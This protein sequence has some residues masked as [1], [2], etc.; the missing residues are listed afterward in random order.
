MARK[1]RAMKDSSGKEAQRKKGVP[2][3]SWGRKQSPEAQLKALFAA[4]SDVIFV[5]DAKGRYL[6]VAPTS[7]NLLSKPAPHLIGQTLHEVFPATQA[8]S[9]LRCIQRTLKS[10]KTVNTEYCL[11]IHGREVWFSAAISPMTRDSVVWVARDI[12]ERKEAER[13]VLRAEE[14]YRSLFSNAVIGMYQSTPEGK[15]LTANPALV[16]MLGFDSLEELLAT[17]IEGSLYVDAKVRKKNLEI[18]HQTGGFV[19]EYEL[20][21][22]DGQRIVVE[23]HARAVKDPAG[24]LLY[25]EGTLID[26]TERRRAEE[27]LKRSEEKYRNL[28]ENSMVGMFRSALADGTILEANNTFL[29][30]FGVES[31]KGAHAEDSYVDPAHREHMKEQ[32]LKNGYVENFE[33]QL[34]RNDGSV[35][36]VS[37][38]GRYHPEDDSLGGVLIDITERKRSEER[39]ERINQCFLS[40]GTDPLENI[41]QL[42]SLCGE[43]LGASYAVYNRL[44]Q[45][46]LCSWGQWKT[47][48]DFKVTDRPEGHLC[49]EVIQKGGNELLLVRQLDQTSYADTDPNVR[50][51]GLRTYMGRCIKFGE[52]SVGSLCVVYQED[53]LPSEDDKR[54]MSVIASAIGVEEM[55]KQAREELRETNQRLQAFI[56]ASPLAIMCLDPEGG[57]TMWSRAAERLFGWNEAEVL[58]KPL[59]IVPKDKQ[60]EFRRLRERVMQEEA[61]T[62]IELR[63]KK[64]DGTWI[65]VSLSAAPLRDSQGQANGMIGLMAD[66]TERKRAEQERQVIYDIMQGVNHT[67]NLDELLRL[68]HRSL[69]RVIYAENCFI[70]L[71]NKQEEV[72]EFPFFVDQF[73]VAPPPLKAGKSCTAFV[74]RMG[75]PILITEEIFR[76]LERQGEVENVGT[77]SP[78]WLGVPLKTPSETIGVLVVQHYEDANAY[79]QRDGEFLASVGNQVALAIDRKRT[80]DKLRQSEERYRHLVDMSPEGIIIHSE[81]KFAFLNPAATQLL[82]AT[83]QDQLIGKPILDFVHSDHREGVKERLYRLLEEGKSVPLK[84]EKLIRLD[85]STVD[86]EVAAI[87]F[88]FD[89]RPAVQVIVRDITARREAENKI[90]RLNRLYS[91]LSKINKAIVRIREPERLYEE[92]CRIVVSEGLFRMAWVGLID[93]E[94]LWVKPVAHWGYEE[95]YLKTLRVS[96]ANIAEGRGPVGTAIRENT[97]SVFNDFQNDVRIL[98]WREEATRRG[99]ASCTALPLRIGARVIGIIALYSGELGFFD[100]DVIRLLDALADDISFALELADQ[101]RQ[102]RQA[103]EA[104]KQS[105]AQ[106]LQ[107]QKMEAVG[108]LA[109]GVAHDFNNFLTAITGYSDLMLMRLPTGDPLRHHAEEIHKAADRAASLTQQLLAFSRKQILQPKVVDLNMVVADVEKM[110]RRLIGEDIELIT[111]L[112]PNL[113]KIKADPGQ[114]V[115]VLMN[116]AVNARDAMAQ[117]GKLIVETASVD[118]DQPHGEMPAGLHVMLSVRDTGCGMDAETKSHI[119]EPFFTTKEKGKGTG[120]GLSTVYGIVKLSGGTIS[121]DSELG[122]GSTFKVYLPRLEEALESGHRG[123]G[124]AS[125][126]R[127]AETVLLVEDEE[128]VRDLVRNILQVHGYTV[129]EAQNGRGAIE[130]CEQHPEHIDLILTD[131][132]MPQM[133]GRELVERLSPMKPDAKILYMS[134]YTDDAILHHGTLESDIPFLQK[135][136]TPDALVLKVREVLDALR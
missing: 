122:Q 26:I 66:I 68:I 37:Y 88:T 72:F 99:Y 29:R 57:V 55:R 15:V 14:K 31:Y 67:A 30:I 21:R 53:Y 92:A 18:F 6:K 77:P 85:G 89:S 61:L 131:V 7:P 41:Q 81:G 59:P 75:R 119:F 9:F 25:C 130:L 5:L 73:D 11:P 56:Q 127:G 82:G 43:M 86:V 39:L 1:S 134:G 65:D 83:T 34:K 91:V 133:S 38:S 20:K 113:G 93:P 35:F 12:S 79:N 121:I 47:P 96:A 36:W 49:H 90:S 17:D 116:L 78:A 2:S 23:E 28:F 124:T 129:L 135:P 108:R 95:G 101:E 114:I 102:R 120:L 125:P 70:A 51:Y 13:T 109:G 60:A 4:M 69:G 24:H 63:R 80:E 54:V 94:T 19:G 8:E 87:P 40:L 128:S 110:L 71:Y 100:D 16:R 32:L 27:A 62:G 45:G 111:H 106:L 50:A 105:E 117:G 84:E 118:L 107:A 126:M 64:K 44:D 104:L 10:Q 22:K 115:Q 97:H 46:L 132:V 76:Q 136:F 48:P 58:R 123:K 112:D 74:Y 42:T 3:K 103:E 98:P 52:K 33:T